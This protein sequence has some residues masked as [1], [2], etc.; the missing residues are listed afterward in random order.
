MPLAALRTPLRNEQMSISLHISI[1]KQQLRL[2]RGGEEIWLASI[3]SGAAGV[4]C[5]KD[6]GK[7]PLGRFRVASRHGEG[8]AP[9]TIF[10]ARLPVGIYPQD[11]REGEKDAILTRI[12]TLDGL[13]EHNANTL[14]RYIYIHGTVAV[15]RLGTPCSMGCIRLSPED[16]LYLYEHCLLGTEVCIEC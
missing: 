1:E 7:T 10:R 12:L 14:E 3:S 9:H 5:E 4:G 2:L 16:M 11:L 6:S 8:A 13:E 15:E